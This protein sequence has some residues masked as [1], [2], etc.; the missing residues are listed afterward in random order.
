MSENKQGWIVSS[1]PHIHSGESVQKIMLS[2]LVALA[3]AMV[4]SWRFFG[5]N[6]LRLTAT[7]VITC[8]LA[9]AICR[10]IMRRIQ[11]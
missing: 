10:K 4:A 1:S 2:V 7:C 6:A 8:I 5:W 9:E 3:P 11:A